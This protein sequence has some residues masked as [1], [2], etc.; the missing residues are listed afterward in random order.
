[1][2]KG[3]PDSTKCGSRASV[4]SVSVGQFIAMQQIQRVAYA[5]GARDLVEAAA[6][7]DHPPVIRGGQLLGDFLERRRQVDGFDLAAWHHHIIDGDRLQFEQIEQDGAVFFGQDV[8]GFQHDGT[9][10]LG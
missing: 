10:F 4:R 8:G 1:M 3:V 9:Q 5:Q 6:I 2:N 7:S